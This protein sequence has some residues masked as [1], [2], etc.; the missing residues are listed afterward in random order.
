VDCRLNDCLEDRYNNYLNP[1]CLV[2]DTVN[3]E[4]MIDEL[5]A[6][7]NAGIRSIIIH[8]HIHNEFGSERWWNDLRALLE[9]CRR[10]DM[11]L[12]ILDTKRF[13]TGNAGDVLV[14][15]YHRLRAWG[16]TEFHMDALGPVKEGSATINH[17]KDTDAEIISVLA[18]KLVADKPHLL[19]GDI[20]DIT[21][22][23]S[24]D[25]VYFDLP[26]GVWRIVII[27]KTQSGINERYAHYVNNLIP[28]HNSLNGLCC[29]VVY[30]NLL[31]A[32]QFCG[33][34]Y[35]A[36]VETVGGELYIP[37]RSDAR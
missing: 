20:I 35:R 37:L 29:F 34:A 8:S 17:L 18:C 14:I 16:I 27:Y 6:V 26:E 3:K 31:F 30:V 15:T 22:G 1:F 12:W 25:M 2:Q 13:P 19:S 36:A 32:K 28:D 33:D 5:R 9:E 4:R 23:I 21:D 7:Y 11:K 10:L 24:G